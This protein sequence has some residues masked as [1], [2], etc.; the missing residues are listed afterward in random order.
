MGIDS[1]MP[2]RSKLPSQDKDAWWKTYLNGHLPSGLTSSTRPIRVVDL[3]SGAGGLAL[4]VKQL[5][6]EMGQ[7]VLTELIVDQ[8]AAASDVYAS[9]HEVRIRSAASVRSLVDF[10]IRGWGEVAQFI[11]PPK[12]LY[13][14][15]DRAA[16]GADLLIAGPPCQ[17]HSNLN[18]RSRRND[19]RNELYLTVPAFA[20]AVGAQNIIIENVPGVIHDHTR[21][22]QTTQSLLENAGYQVTSGVLAADEMGW[23]QARRRFFM[24]ARQKH[25]P[26][27]LDIVASGLSDKKRR[28]VLWALGG[29][30]ANGSSDILDQLTDHSTENDKRI[31]WLFAN[32]QYELP[33][34]ERP[35]CHRNGTT[36][37]SVYGRMRPDEPSPTITTG[38]MSPGRGRF[39]HP[40]KPR[41]LTAREA[42]ALQGFPYTYRFVADPN[43]PPT[44]T[45]LAKWIG[46]AVPMPLGYAATLSALGPDLPSGE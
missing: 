20:I 40:T 9:N 37:S 45:Q 18:N 30:E 22:V 14:Q 10:R 2:R 23:P 5:V 6:A 34:S 42:A 29:L 27:A 12:V 39:V 31:K 36:Y 7:R 25:P 35:E 26:I 17:G 19:K 1:W 21:V 4:G 13:P 24:V 32:S 46:D 43:Q 15:L 3:F 16:S 28:S 44:R 41:T 33:A 8:D 11:Y 38:F